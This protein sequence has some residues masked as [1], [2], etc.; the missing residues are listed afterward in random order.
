MLLAPCSTALCCVIVCCFL[1]VLSSCVVPFGLL[2]DIGGV[3]LSPRVQSK[4]YAW[5][6]TGVTAL[7]TMEVMMM[8]C[9]GCVLLL[10]VCCMCVVFGDVID[11]MWWPVTVG[12]VLTTDYETNHHVLKLIIMGVKNSKN[13]AEFSELTLL[14]WFNKISKVATFCMEIPR[15]L[16]WGCVRVGNR[17]KSFFVRWRTDRPNR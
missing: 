15:Q 16:K 11:A 4:A 17:E 5:A 14:I 6:T 12:V 13:I 3:L 1:P 10:G 7:G 2:A 8:F 9:V